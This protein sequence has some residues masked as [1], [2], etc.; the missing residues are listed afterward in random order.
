MSSPAPLSPALAPYGHPD[1]V[2]R[3]VAAFGAVRCPKWPGLTKPIS[4]WGSGTA[5]TLTPDAALDAIRE[6]ILRLNHAHGVASTP[7]SGYHET[8]TRGYMRLIGRFVCEAGREGEWD[9]RANRLLERLGARE[10]LLF[11]YSSDRL[12]SPAARAGWVEPDLSP[13]P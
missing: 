11:Y 2:L 3:L 6:G 13:L 8:I 12:M 10:V 7:T 1:D 9:E 4:P 5:S